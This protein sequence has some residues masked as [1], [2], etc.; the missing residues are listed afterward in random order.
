MALEDKSWGDLPSGK[1]GVLVRFK[2]GTKTYFWYDSKGKRDTSYSGLKKNSK[3][4][5]STIIE[6]IKA[7]R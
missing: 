5:N 3:K 7:H 1:F 2:N 4:P 6:V